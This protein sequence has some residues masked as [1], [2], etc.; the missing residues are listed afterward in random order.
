MIKILNPNTSIIKYFNKI[1]P[2]LYC[3]KEEFELLWNLKPHNRPK[4]KI[5]NKLIETPRWFQSYGEDYIFSG[6]KHESTQIND[7]IQKYINYANSL[8]EKEDDFDGN[9]F[10]MV[11]I[12][13][14]KDGEDYIGF[15]SDNEK[16]LI[17]NSSIYCFSFGCNRDFI[18]KSIKSSNK[19]IINLENN[20]LII[21]KGT[22]QKTHKHSI[23]IRKKIKERR[24]SITLRKFK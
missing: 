4:I 11:L 10:N 21:M 24:I 9:Y 20:S 3:N 7:F 14:Y 2:N 19:E 13:W 15:H 5:F 12:N 1:D 23:P 16:Q 8:E 6:I 22:C 17:E 18:I